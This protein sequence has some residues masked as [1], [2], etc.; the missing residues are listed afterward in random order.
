MVKTNDPVGPA[1]RNSL[2]RRIFADDS[3]FGL[4]EI[5]VS[6]VLLG[7]VAVSFLPV[8]ID[9]LT[10]SARNVTT[11]TATQLVNDQLDD[12]V[13]TVSSCAELKAFLKETPAKV[14]DSQH[15]ELQPQRSAAATCDDSARGAV[16]FTATVIRTD[17]NATV[18]TATT[19]LSVLKEPDPASSAS[20]SPTPAP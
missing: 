14:M 3:G 2:V 10:V 19:L 17:T 15:V 11:A 1:G 12:A 18:S 5:L 7:V 20:P 4:V 6:M 9:S 13:A 8:L 16:V